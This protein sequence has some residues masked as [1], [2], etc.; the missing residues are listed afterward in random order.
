M[1]KR[2]VLSI[3]IASVSILFTAC[4]MNSSEEV[5][6]EV[7][8]SEEI[9][10]SEET[11][12][13][14][15]VDEAVTET[16]LTQEEFAEKFGVMVPMKMNVVNGSQMKVGM[17]MIL[18]PVSNEGIA[19]GELDPDG[20]MNVDLMWPLK[21]NELEWAILDSNKEP[22]LTGTTDITGFTEG[23]NIVLLGEETIDDFDVTIK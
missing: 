2:I 8:T 20:M 18:D 19:I 23:V 11:F 14:E 16:E 3:V 6:S 22:Y 5:V 9:I 13:S 15:S 4:E 17:F 12:V 10:T 1:K 7:V 21:I